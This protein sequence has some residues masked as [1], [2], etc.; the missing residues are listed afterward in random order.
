ME[1]DKGDNVNHRDEFGFTSL[2]RAVAAN[3][4]NKVKAL[5]SNPKID[6]NEKD[7][8]SGW[9]AFH[10]ALY[11]GNLRIALLL[12]Q[13]KSIDLTVED[14]ERCTA[15][16]LCQE[17]LPVSLKE[18]PCPADAL[19]TW[20]SN[21]NFTL[22][23]NDSDDR[24]IPE[25]VKF[26]YRTNTITFPR[27]KEAKPS[28]LNLST[29]K[30]HTTITTTEQGHTAKIWGFGT[31]GRLGS[32]RKMQLNPTSVTGIAGAI[33]SSALGRDH[34]VFITT[35]GEVY[36]L[37]NNKYCQLGYVSDI[38]K[39]GQDPI[40]ITPKRVVLN[41]A[42][43]NIIG[44]AASRWH[45]V[46]HTKS[47]VFTFGFNY[48][49]LG[50]ERNGDV[51]VGPRKVASIPHESE[52][53]LQVVASDSATACLMSS[54]DVIV[55]HK[56]VYHKVNFSF[57]PY[58]EWY[59]KDSYSTV[60]YENRPKKISCSEN[61]FGVMT[62]MGDIHVWSYPEADA[63]ITLGSL[64]PNH[65]F[66]SI[67]A[68]YD[69]PRRI[70]LYGGDRTHV[71]DFA[72]GQNG[73]VI[74][75]TRGGHVYI[76][77]NKGTSVGKN[78]K[79]Q[80]V[81]HLN[82]VVQV[83]ANSGGAWVALRSEPTLT[84]VVIRHGKL[85][86][87]LEQ[88]L[89]QFHLYRNNEKSWVTEANAPESNQVGDGQKGIVT[90]PMTINGFEYMVEVTD[91]EEDDQKEEEKDPWKIDTQ[92]WQNIEKSWDFD[93]VPLLDL[94]LRSEG[95]KGAT[96]SGSHLFDVELQAGKRV[97]G[98]HRIILSARSIVFHRALVDAP[99]SAMKVGSLVTIEPIKD[100]STSRILYTVILKVEFTAAVLLLQFL[101]SDRFDPFWDALDLPKTNKQ[102]AQKVRQELYH[103]SL[104][105]A[106]PTL[107]AALQY[108]FTHA[109]SPSL[110]MNMSQVVEESSRFQSLSDVRLLLKDGKFMDAHQVVLG[111]RSVFFNAFFVRTEEWMRERQG[112]RSLPAVGETVKPDILQLNMKHMD[113]ES[114]E[115]VMRYI[116]TDCGPELFDKI[117][118]DDMDD[119]IQVVINVLMIAD[120]LLL[121][122]LKDICEKVLGE[123]VRAKTVVTF[124]EVALMYTADSL[125][126][127]CIDYL[128]DNVEM[129]LDQRWLEGADD[130]ILVLVEESLKKKQVSFMPYSRSGGYLPTPEKVKEALSF[131]KIH[132]HIHFT[133]AGV[134]S[135]E[136]FK[137]SYSDYDTNHKQPA[138]RSMSIAT[139]PGKPPAE[140]V[141]SVSTPSLPSGGRSVGASEPASEEQLTKRTILSSSENITQWPT[142]S[143][144]P[145]VE[146]RDFP[147]YPTKKT[148]WGQVVSVEALQANE[149][150]AVDG[151]ST[152]TSL[153]D[154]LELE[155]RQGQAGG[156]KSL[157]GTHSTNAP[158]ATKIS[159]KERRK[160]LQQQ[161]QV[162]SSPP[163]S[164]NLIPSAP[165]VW[166]KIA[167]ASPLDLGDGTGVPRRHSGPASSSSGASV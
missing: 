159:Q 142:L 58:P 118:K 166:G 40:Q 9:T 99:R 33:S 46:V 165:P 61:K 81:P 30:F 66:P 147:Q 140:L 162:S 48:G 127:T 164:G 97:L 77:T 133:M 123:Q 65:T 71:I 13:H 73:S 139:I 4:I 143:D 98:A 158:K 69:K 154:I 114:M 7:L 64:P 131:I 26:P 113:L 148:G 67:A 152:K 54:F 78:V 163:E 136:L 102:Y 74:V 6:V 17:T 25:L 27:V 105:L 132:G 137:G 87:D 122:R 80:R 126:L 149:S 150:T 55:F 38:P 36:T 157:A 153:R 39:N 34:T 95:H 37:G 23:H 101:Y 49:Q 29:S 161:Q 68:S 112:P 111:H 45:T 79:W 106:L 63:N 120:E 117:E 84:P 128:C 76:G 104:E 5:L 121:D 14:K 130:D 134:P 2:H 18:G 62:R 50:Y 119:L 89:S 93:L 59:T 47:E 167:A 12:V 115:L 86:A 124:L 3:N 70:W 44:A 8:E 32:D 75:L 22:G 116:Y 160:L 90:K 108:S 60:L 125:K 15:L 91:D 24:K 94:T 135:Y 110:S 41:I 85:G 96:V 103:L 31:N 72:M 57:F 155:E 21:S 156:T 42:K 20:G 53:I 11:F 10:R 28:F 35:R 88:S 144:I 16:D 138:A 109:C 83:Y 92:G 141:R 82:R 52:T 129:M 56:Y 1:K 145:I 151:T 146:A 107:Q 19:Y 43:L 51:Q 100:K